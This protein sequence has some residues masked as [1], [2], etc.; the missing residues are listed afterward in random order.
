MVTDQEDALKLVFLFIKMNVL[1][2]LIE[3]FSTYQ[4]AIAE[5]V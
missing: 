1:T 4:Q 3:T 2:A 5:M